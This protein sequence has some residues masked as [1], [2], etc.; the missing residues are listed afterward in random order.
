[1]KPVNSKCSSIQ[2]RV[3]SAIYSLHDLLHNVGLI[4]LKL[5]KANGTLCTV[6]LKRAFKL[7]V[8]ADDTKAEERRLGNK[9]KLLIMSERLQKSV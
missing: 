2:L 7:Y 5:D 8:G 6:A 4:N 1:M 3:N 9:Q